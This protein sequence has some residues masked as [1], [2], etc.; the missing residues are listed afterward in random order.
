VSGIL[1]ESTRSKELWF[2]PDTSKP[3]SSSRDCMVSVVVVKSCHTVTDWWAM[4]MSTFTGG[5]D[6]EKSISFIVRTQL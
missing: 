4:D 5:G 6:R 2:K 3:A 1:W